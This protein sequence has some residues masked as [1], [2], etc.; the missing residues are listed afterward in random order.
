MNLQEEYWRLQAEEG[1]DD[2]W[3]I[4]RVG[5]EAA[6]GITTSPVVDSAEKTS[7]KDRS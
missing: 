4:K 5:S 2:D 7:A 1:D 3:E 6:P